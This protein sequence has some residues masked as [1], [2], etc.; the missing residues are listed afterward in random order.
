MSAMWDATIESTANSV[1][2]GEKAT[3]EIEIVERSRS[4]VEFGHDGGLGI[5]GKEILYST[6]VVVSS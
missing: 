5:I 4:G 2:V 1:T 6:F 3:F